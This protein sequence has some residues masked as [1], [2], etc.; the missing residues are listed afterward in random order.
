MI[1]LGLV[2]PP[3]S[4]AFLA[5]GLLS[6]FCDVEPSALNCSLNLLADGAYKG[7]LC[8]YVSKSEL[9]FTNASVGLDVVN[10]LF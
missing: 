5:L 2:K 9:N 6:P 10:L 7:L 3:E 4:V 1:Y 8:V